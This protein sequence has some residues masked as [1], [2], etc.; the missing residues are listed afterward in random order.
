[1][2]GLAAVLGPLLEALNEKIDQDVLKMDNLFNILHFR[3]VFLILRIV[4]L[5]EEKHTFEEKL[6][7]NM[8]YEPLYYLRHGIEIFTD[9]LLWHMPI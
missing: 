5:Y 4:L 8:K 6:I 2:T 9:Y 3:L 1:M 7:N